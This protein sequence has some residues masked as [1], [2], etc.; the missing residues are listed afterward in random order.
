MRDRIL[1]GV[2]WVVLNLVGSGVLAADQPSERAGVVLSEFLY[3]SAPYPS[4][5]AST[6]VEVPGGLVAAWFGGTAERNPDVGIWVARHDG[7]AW[8]T[9]VEV[10]RG[11][12]DGKRLPCW[13]PVLFQPSSGP[14]LLFSKIGPDPRHWWGVM[15]SSSDGGRTWSAAKRLPDPALGPIKDKPIERPA[16]TLLCPSSVEDERWRVAFERTAD[17][18]RTWT[19]SDFVAGVDRGIDAIQPC[20]LTHPDGRL[21]ALCRSRRNGIV[22]TWSGD[23]GATWSPLAETGLPNPN[24]GI[25]ATTLADGRH[26]LVYNHQ[27]KGRSPL[28]VAV[29]RDGKTWQAGV[30]LETEPGEFSYPAM[31]QTSDG[32]VHVTYTWNRR[33][34]RHVVLDPA[35]LVVRDLGSFGPIRPVEPR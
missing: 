11:E 27:T 17:L 35:K 21:Q 24:S 9:P 28:N 8:S 32:R 26:L 22:E 31:I 7:K 12:E 2:A 29:S 6:I 15:Q 1:P 23:G 5:H 14:L 3:E 19:R 33:K 30:T 10:L 20:L 25:D 13:N 18:G 34:I 4:C 16:G